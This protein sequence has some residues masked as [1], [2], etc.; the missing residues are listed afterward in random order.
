V[1]EGP[2]HALSP[3]ALKAF[4]EGDNEV[5]W[6]VY[7]EGGGSGFHVEMDVAK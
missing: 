2:P 7:Q 3:A 1:A 4:R 5:V 6:K